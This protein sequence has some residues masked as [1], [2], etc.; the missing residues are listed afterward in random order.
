[1]KYPTYKRIPKCGFTLVEIMIVVGIIGII[2]AMAIPAFQKSRI[3]SQATRVANDLKKLEQAFDILLLERTMPD[4]VYERNGGPSGFPTADLP[5]EIQS[6]P[7]GSNSQVSYDIN[8]GL[9]GSGNRGVVISDG[10]GLD[11]SMLIELDEIL[12]DGDINTG[13]G[14]KR[15]A[16]QYVLVVGQI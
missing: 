12:D 1:M 4:G 6:Q 8:D 9:T 16:N 7:L 11:D 13:N 14:T 15:N 3:E 2:A 10:S 5:E